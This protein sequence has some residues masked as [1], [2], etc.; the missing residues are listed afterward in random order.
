M[1]KTRKMAVILLGLLIC[2]L[3]LLYFSTKIGRKSFETLIASCEE[4]DA[5]MELRTESDFTLI[6]DIKFNEE[7]L[8]YDE[9]D[10]T[11]YYSLIE[12]GKR[13][14]NPIITVYSSGEKINIAFKEYSIAE[15][16][17]SSNA[18]IEF[19]AYTDNSY[20][21]YK[22]RCTT[23]PVMNI[24]CKEEITEEDTV[25]NMTLFDNR[26]EALQRVTSSAGK[27]HIRGGSTKSFPKLGYKLSLTMESIGGNKRKNTVSLLGMRK[28]ED[29]I[30]YAAYNDQEKIRNVFSSNLW[31]ESCGNDNS[32][33]LE[34]GM[35]YEY[36][37]LF[38]NGNYWG[39]Y[40]LGYPIDDLQLGIG[41][42]SEEC[43]YKKVSWNSEYP[44]EYTEN[45]EIEGYRIASK[46][47]DDWNL[48]YDYYEK[49]NDLNTDSSWFHSSI[50]LENAVDYALFVNLIQ[51]KDNAYYNTIKNVYITAKRCEDGTYTYLY[52]PWDMDITWGNG[53]SPDAKNLTVPYESQSTKNQPV[54][55]GSLNK[56]LV[57]DDDIAWNAYLNQYHELREGLWSEETIISTIDEYEHQIF[58]SGAYLRDMNRWPDGSYENPELKLSVFKEYVLERLQETDRY[59]DKLKDVKDKGIYAIRTAL[60]KNFDSSNFLIQL[61]K[62]YR[63]DKDIVSLL[64]YIGIKCDDIPNGTGFVLYNKA[65][66]NIEYREALEASGDRFETCIGTVEL[67]TS[68]NVEYENTNQYN[69]YVNGKPWFIYDKSDND[70]MNV[71][72]ESD[73]DN[74]VN[75]LWLEK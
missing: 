42:Q 14:F 18:A 50:D 26:E 66:N 53:W 59:F 70:N 67:V 54:E 10:S 28:D 3:F 71:V 4:Y 27:M 74:I 75:S 41:E 12:N 8:F 33:G 40:A 52:T 24:D 49:Q 39:L 65:E 62:D 37:E 68:D 25:V 48:L 32:F 60:Y 6:R 11:Y 5:I 46:G 55:V 30:L 9:E 19:I 72:F 57:N 34:N 45:G 13:A 63:N 58:D 21:K 1:L 38:L 15:N 2:I 69:V 31:T 17:I 16:I 29:W 43:I 7:K 23:L 47:K 64:E 61:S 36:I 22:L 51:G 35:K 44:I 73:A 20:F 56:L